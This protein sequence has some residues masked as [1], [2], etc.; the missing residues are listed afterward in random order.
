MAI[1]SKSIL[2]IMFLSSLVWLIGG[3]PDPGLTEES[4]KLSHKGLFYGQPISIMIKS[5]DQLNLTESQVTEM[6]RL[7]NDFE[8]KVRT[9]HKE[10]VQ[11]EEELTAM[12]EQGPADAAAIEN[13]V[14]SM[15]KIRADLQLQRIQTI[16]EAQK[17]L[18]TEQREQCEK[19]MTG[20]SKQV[21]TKDE[22]E[23]MPAGHCGD[24][25]MGG[26]EAEEQSIES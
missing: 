10:L 15:E 5:K 3:L 22:Q 16:L 25:S 9:V 23:S 2:I 13:K 4:A 17:L 6:K 7:R 11:L 8:E 20:A 21:E 24:G 18:T 19:L 1:K 14:R 26:D 12:I